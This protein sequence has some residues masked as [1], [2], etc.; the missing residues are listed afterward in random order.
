MSR[1][2]ALC[3]WTASVATP[4]RHLSAP[5]A[6]VVARSSYGIALT[7][8]CGRTTVATFLALLLRCKVGSM[9]HRLREW[10][11]EADAKAGTKRQALEVTTCFVP[12]LRWIVHLWH[13]TALALALDATS[14]S[15]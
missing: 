15:D 8:S 3:E 10:C 13:G 5:Q 4:L 11:Y 7:R 2:D 9:E 12:L 1:E 14:L 6:T